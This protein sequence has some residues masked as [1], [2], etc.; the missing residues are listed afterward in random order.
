MDNC[1]P[2][3]TTADW[4]AAVG[5]QIHFGPPYSPDL[6]AAEFPWAPLKST[7]NSLPSDLL[8]PMPDLLHS[9]WIKSTASRSRLDD[10]KAKLFVNYAN[11]L[12]RRGGI[13]GQTS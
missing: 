7:T 6:N 4:G 5:I 3:R 8:I 1:G 2:H 9:A 10:Y 12:D 13:Q 11:C